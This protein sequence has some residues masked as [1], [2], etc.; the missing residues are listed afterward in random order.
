MEIAVVGSMNMDMIIHADRIPMKGETIQGRKIEYQPGGKGAN[1]A[2]AMAKLGAHVTMFG[3]VGNDAVGK[4]LIENMS[5]YGI[6]TKNVNIMEDVP[7][8]QA[9]ITVGQGEN[10]ILII[11]GAN[12][13][14]DVKYAEKHSSGILKADIIVL[15]NEI[16]EETVEYVIRLC[17]KHKKI[18]VWNPAPARK[19]EQELLDMITFLTPNEHEAR[20]IWEEEAED[21]VRL[22][23]RYPNKLII[24]Q[25]EKGV[26]MGV[27]GNGIIT[28]PAIK[29]DVKDT[30]GAG[31]TLNG[32]FCVGISRKM[33]EIDALEFANAAAGLSVQKYGAQMGMP[34]SA[35]VEKVLKVHSLYQQVY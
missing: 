21:T 28:F 16:P 23:E 14:V 25:G 31:D 12:N 4:K 32:A 33:K 34:V 2:V 7:T 6:N 11:A 20:I 29:V 24:T 18:I 13:C 1:Q 35:E 17:H 10:T 30:T 9:M 26:S 27:E 8:G 3:C 15:Q 22:L 19:L 5:Q